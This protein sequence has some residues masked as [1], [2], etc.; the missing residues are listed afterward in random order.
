MRSPI[1]KTRPFPRSKKQ[2]I[3]MMM[4]QPNSIKR[5]ILVKGSTVVFGFD[6][7]KFEKLK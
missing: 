6:K 1:F 7:T 3:E 5:P 4:E 2:A